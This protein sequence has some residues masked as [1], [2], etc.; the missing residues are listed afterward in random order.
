M[1]LHAVCP[2]ALN[3]RTTPNDAHNLSRA[4]RS[5]VAAHAA[6]LRSGY[7][8]FLGQINIAVVSLFP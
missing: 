2:H 6:H 1:K 8:T 3:F 5:A 4:R 7:F